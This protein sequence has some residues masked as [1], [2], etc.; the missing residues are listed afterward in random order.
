MKRYLIR[1]TQDG[2]ESTLYIMC[3]GKSQALVF[4]EMALPLA[5]VISI[6]RAVVQ[7]ITQKP[8][9]N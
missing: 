1:F 6:E 3:Y 4:F 2:E 8:C 5:K 9:L 7:I